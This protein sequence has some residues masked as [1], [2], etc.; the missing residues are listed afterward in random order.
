M[1]L[2]VSLLGGRFCFLFQSRTPPGTACEPSSLRVYW[3]SLVGFP[4]LIDLCLYIYMFSPSE[5][6]FGFNIDLSYPVL[7]IF[8]RGCCCAVSS[9]SFAFRFVFRSY[10]MRKKANTALHFRLIMCPLIHL[11]LAL[12]Q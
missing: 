11:A 10:P 7:F 8:P 3:Y 12:Q 4:F 2:F 5:L 1:V 9:V 6:G